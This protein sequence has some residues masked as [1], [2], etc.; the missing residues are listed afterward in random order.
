M[1]QI[2]N[3]GIPAADA[4][5]LNPL[6]R[7][8]TAAM[9]E[10]E[11]LIYGH[12]DFDESDESQLVSWRSTEYWDAR[13]FVA[14][15][16]DADPS[17]PEPAD[18]LGIAR[19]F[20]PLKEDL[21]TAI[22]WLWVH[23]QARGR[24]V[25]R[26]LAEV[27]EREIRESGRTTVQVWRTAGIVSQDAPG[28]IIPPTGFGA[29]DGE[30]PEVRWLTR[31]GFALEQVERISTLAI[32]TG[33]GERKAWF[34]VVG[35]MREEAGARASGYRL[36]TWEGPTPPEWRE[37]YAQ[38]QRRMSVDVPSAGLSLGERD[39]TVERIVYDE[40]QALAGGRQWIVV[41]A[42]HEE[43]GELVAYTELEWPRPGATGVWQMDTFVHGEH[44]G[45]RIGMWIKTEM[46]FRLVV[47]H[48]AAERIHTWNADE[49]GYMLTINEAL[50]FEGVAYESAWE[51]RG[52]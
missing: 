29:V 49:N 31:R 26:A 10:A 42:V 22:M 44:R 3:T 32:P 28:A 24:G 39:I 30:A 21:E 18:V 35:Q 27:I 36:V 8:S 23:P 1:A 7:A 46:L 15:T 37:T 50:G 20:L 5:E 17:N 34:D 38:L 48:P 2:V 12:N 43:S 40:Q 41:A 9:R 6:Q 11:H 33:E 25:G 47:A 13:R 51:L 4:T 45:H 52:I 14:L 19:V 16:D